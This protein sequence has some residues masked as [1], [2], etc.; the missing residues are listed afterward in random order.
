MPANYLEAPSEARVLRK[1]IQDQTLAY[2]KRYIT[3]DYVQFTE[4]GVAEI[5]SACLHP[6]SP[7]APTDISLPIDPVDKLLASRAQDLVPYMEEFKLSAEEQHAVRGVF[8]PNIRDS[9][10][11]PLSP[12]LTARARK[13]TPRILQR[14]PKQVLGMLP[15]NM[16]EILEKGRI[17]SVKEQ[18]IV[19]EL[20]DRDECL[21]VESF[22]PLPSDNTI[23][24]SRDLEY[25]MTPEMIQDFRRFMACLPNKKTKCPPAGYEAFLR[26]ESPPPEKSFPGRMS[27]PLFPRSE[28]IGLGRKGKVGKVEQQES[29]SGVIDALGVTVA[30]TDDLGFSL[31]G[32]AQ[33]SMKMLCGD[34]DDILEPS[35]PLPPQPPA[36]HWSSSDAAQ[37]SSPVPQTP[38]SLRPSEMAFFASSPPDSYDKMAKIAKFDE[39]LFP[40][41]QMRGRKLSLNKNQPKFA[42]FIAGLNHPVPIRPS[43]HAAPPIATILVPGTPSVSSRSDS[44]VGQPD[45]EID[46]LAEDYSAGIPSRTG[47]KNPSR[48][49]SKNF[50]RK[51]SKL[52]RIASTISIQTESQ[53]SVPSDVDQLADDDTLVACVVERLT[54]GVGDPFDYIMKERIEEKEMFMLDVP[55]L[56]PPNVHKHDGPPMPINLAETSSQLGLCR[57]GGI[58]S[59]QIELDW[60]VTIPGERHPTHEQVAKADVPYEIETKSEAKGKIKSF[61]ARLDQE[62]VAA[63]VFE[64]EEPTV[65]IGGAWAR[66]NMK[67]ILTKGERERLYGVRREPQNVDDEHLEVSIPMDTCE[68][69]LGEGAFSHTQTTFVPLSFGLEPRE[70][71]DV[72]PVGYDNFDPQGY[73]PDELGYQEDQTL[74]LQ[75]HQGAEV[76]HD[77]FGE[78]RHEEV[79]EPNY[80]DENQ[81]AQDELEDSQVIFEKDRVPEREPVVD[82]FEILEQTQ[83]ASQDQVDYIEIEDSPP[84]VRTPSRV[85]N[86]AT[87]ELLHPGPTDLEIR[88]EWRDLQPS[89][90]VGQKLASFMYARTG[91]PQQVVNV[92]AHS[93]SLEPEAF[94]EPERTGPYPIPSEIET[95]LALRP[96]ES[97]QEHE[98]VRYKIISNMQVIQHRALVQALEDPSVNLQLVERAGEVLEVSPWQDAGPPLHGASFAIDPYTAAVLVP[99]ADLPGPDAVPALSR[100]VQSLLG[101]YDTIAL[102][103]EAYSKSKSNVE[104]DPFTPPA[105]KALGAVRRA[106]ALINGS[107][108]REGVKVGI[109]RNVAECARLVRGVVDVAA[110]EWDGAWEVWG[111]RE[112]IGDEEVSEERELSLVPAMNVFASITILA[113]TTI[114]ELLTQSPEERSALFAP[115]IGAV[116][117]AALNEAIEQGR[118]R[119]EQMDGVE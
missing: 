16:E 112:W 76:E 33:E 86:D 50:S 63:G 103:L 34:M 49:T 11:R 7:H 109:A 78:Y 75:T 110:Q 43:Q 111:S 95:M 42:E 88:S 1:H 77:D 38:R 61:L 64:G 119:V 93:H 25:T 48:R 52:S 89:H 113:Q 60:R 66:E 99:L 70:G 32:I 53:A 9:P 107:L 87:R 54:E 96:H 21:C 6:V 68:P 115:S 14:P 23:D 17:H 18:E 82:W 100:L 108:A 10:L 79:E 69:A 85:Q 114:D 92:D 101:R 47:S 55:D 59:L 74:E 46:E 71:W 27:P 8:G 39:V 56:P 116:R 90:L 40:K 106:I 67:L 118:E 44:V 3:T 117:I 104:L 97:E 24:E 35:S 65:E 41:D 30:P 51:N 91:K 83:D 73:E 2:A 94:P 45:D 58:Q 57:A 26:A 28:T 4:Q 62:P 20:L 5:F 36:L 31:D 98:P 12:I 29:L 72:E 19:D 81:P 102:V 105:R 15:A 37:P 22:L 80:E 13:E 84:P